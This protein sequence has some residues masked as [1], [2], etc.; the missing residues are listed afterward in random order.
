MRDQ[1][2]TARTSWGATCV[3][4]HDTRMWSGDTR[5]EVLAE[6]TDDVAAWV[7]SE[8]IDL[9]LTLTVIL[10]TDVVWCLGPSEEWAD[11][12]GED[13]CYCGGPHDEHDR[14]AVD[15]HTTGTATLRVYEGGD[16]SVRVEEATHAP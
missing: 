9:P 5:A 7:N 15:Y 14:L 1:P 2:G 16:G 3:E 6:V 8:G 13:G 11:E 4:V 12:Y 10:A